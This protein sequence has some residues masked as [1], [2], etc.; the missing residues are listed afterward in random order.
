M[1][2]MMA[3]GGGGLG[4]MKGMMSGDMAGMGQ[5][6]VKQRSKRKR[7]I[8]RKGKKRKVR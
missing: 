8:V 2:K 4:A 1:M 5:R 6:K 3:A 7:V